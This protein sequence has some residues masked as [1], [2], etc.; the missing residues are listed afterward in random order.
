MK[1]QFRHQSFQAYATNT[2]CDMFVGRSFR[3]PKL[4]EFD[5]RIISPELGRNAK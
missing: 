3:A 4:M 2:V 5:A 1:P